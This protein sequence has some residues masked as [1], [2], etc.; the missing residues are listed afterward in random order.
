MKGAGVLL[1]LAF[2]IPSVALAQGIPIR[3]EVT[4]YVPLEV[5]MWNDPPKKN[6]THAFKYKEACKIQ[7]GGSI[8][9]ERYHI[10]TDDYTVRYYVQG[11][12]EGI[13]CPDGTI[14]FM[15]EKQLKELLKQ[16]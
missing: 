1:L 6:S 9:V 3:S 7:Q 4:I 12:Q 8:R 15:E 14:F 16:K 13:S 11:L 10:D 5:E 2:L